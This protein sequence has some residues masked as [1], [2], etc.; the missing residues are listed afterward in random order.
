MPWYNTG[1][2]VPQPADRPVSTTHPRWQ[3][4]GQMAEDKLR[5]SIEYC[6]S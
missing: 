1:R 4:V 5:V 6:T 2:R 3:E